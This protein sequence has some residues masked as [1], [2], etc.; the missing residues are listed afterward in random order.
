M[1][2]DSSNLNDKEF[3]FYVETRGEVYSKSTILGVGI[4]DG[5][6]GYFIDSDNL[7]N[8]KDLFNSNVNKMTYDLKKNIVVLNNLDININNCNYD[9]MIGMYLLDYTVKDDISF[10]AKSFSYDIT[11]YEDLYGTEKR[12]KE[13]SKDELSKICALKAKFILDMVECPASKQFSVIQLYGTPYFS[14]HVFSA[15]SL[16]S[17]T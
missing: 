1:R 16:N 7:S 13:I 2:T 9:S 14:K 11:P 15:F 6:K 12:P 5:E 8:Y 4:Y 3:S 10:V 17:L